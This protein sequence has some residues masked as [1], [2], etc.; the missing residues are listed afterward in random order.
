MYKPEND[1]LTMGYTLE[2]ASAGVYLP[3]Q[4]STMALS[5]RLKSPSRAG[6]K[7]PGLRGLVGHS[8]QDAIDTTKP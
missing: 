7:N 1:N 5:G 6:K 3:G 4:G 8:I 2:I